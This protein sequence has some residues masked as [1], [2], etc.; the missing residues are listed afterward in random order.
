MKRFSF[1]SLRSRI[2]LL[3]FVILLPVLLLLFYSAHEQRHAA[4]KAV[5]QNVIT[6]AN[7]LSGLIEQK[8][9]G[10]RELLIALSHSSVVTDRKPELCKEKIAEIKRMNKLF[11]GRELRMIELKE[12]IMELEKQTGSSGK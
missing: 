3:L 6:Q 10:A 12:R 7:L 8:A 5:E 1:S 9:E 2:L 11:V 4:A